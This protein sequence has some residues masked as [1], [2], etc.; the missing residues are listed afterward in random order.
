MQWYTVSNLF[1]TFLKDIHDKNISQNRYYNTY[2]DTNNNNK[3]FE[4]NYDI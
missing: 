3:M 4:N 2:V 1:C